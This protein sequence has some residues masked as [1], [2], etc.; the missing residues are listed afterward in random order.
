MKGIR[1]VAKAPLAAGF[2]QNRF[3]GV[4]ANFPN[5]NDTLRVS[6]IRKKRGVYTRYLVRKVRVHMLQVELGCMERWVSGREGAEAEWVGE[7]EGGWVTGASQGVC[8]CVCV[9]VRFWIIINNHISIITFI[10]L[11]NDG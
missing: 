9:C 3:G 10:I 4:K 1:F 2:R 5:I 6:I 8:L 7:K 11:K